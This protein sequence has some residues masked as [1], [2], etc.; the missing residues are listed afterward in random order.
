MLYG[1]VSMTDR[2]FDDLEHDTQEEFGGPVG[3]EI[4]PGPELTDGQ[5][6]KVETREELAEKRRGIRPPQQEGREAMLAR[7]YRIQKSDEERRLP[8][9]DVWLH[10]EN[11]EIWKPL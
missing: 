6:D 5:M 1:D 11:P 3:L 4:P 10:P 9:D 2:Y 7:R 8:G